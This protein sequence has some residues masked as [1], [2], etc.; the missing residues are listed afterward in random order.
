MVRPLISLLSLS[1]LTSGCSLIE[2]VT[3]QTLSDCDDLREQIVELSEKDR[4]KDG[5]SIVKIY[6]PQET[7]RSD[8]EI[9]CRGMAHWSDLDKTPI[10]YRNYVDSEGEVMI[11]FKVSQ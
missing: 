9:A 10:T 5:Y 6:E 11:E 2:S 3:S 4:A 1:L 7:S 8:Q